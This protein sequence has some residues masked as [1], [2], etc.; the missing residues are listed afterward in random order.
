MARLVN[1]PNHAETKYR[2]DAPQVASLASPPMLNP[3]QIVGGGVGDRRTTV[4]LCGLEKAS[5]VCLFGVRVVV[6]SVDLPC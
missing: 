3:L 5:G 6:E 4:W 2:L 1:V